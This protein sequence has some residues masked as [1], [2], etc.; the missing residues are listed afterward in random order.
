MSHGLGGGIERYVETL[1]WAFDHE[2]VDYQRVNLH[3]SGLAAHARRGPQLSAVGCRS[4]SCNPRASKS[5]SSG[6]AA[7]AG[8]PR[9]WHLGHLP[10]MRPVGQASTAAESFR[11]MPHASAVVCVV[12]AS[13]FTS[14]ALADSGPRRFCRLACHR[15]DLTRWRTHPP[16]RQ[17]SIGESPWLLHSVWKTG[18]IKGCHNCS[19]PLR[20]WVVLT[21]R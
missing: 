16:T 9:Q 2:G 11:E 12:T 20:P 17:R 18:E 4:G 13:S 15:S 5:P 10:R 6:A 8:S 7:C 21:F 14:G 1:E 3:R 19:M